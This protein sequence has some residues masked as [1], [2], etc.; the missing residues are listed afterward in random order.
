MAV[1][2]LEVGDDVST[3]KTSGNRH[4][5]SSH[6]NRTR[7]FYYIY[8]ERAA[9]SKSSERGLISS[10]SAHPHLLVQESPAGMTGAG[11]RVDTAGLE[12]LVRAAVSMLQGGAR[13]LH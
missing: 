3:N 13:T 11:A 7:Y 8:C 9:G 4:R 1:T 12:T 5:A 2:T 6:R 10:M